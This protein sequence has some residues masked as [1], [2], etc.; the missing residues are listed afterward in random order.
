M[1]AMSRSRDIAKNSS[2]TQNYVRL[3]D[4]LS[5]TECG[6]AVVCGIIDLEMNE[7]ML[8]IP[9]TD[10]LNRKQFCAASAIYSCKKSKSRKIPIRIINPMVAVNTL[11]KGTILGKIVSYKCYI[12]DYNNSQCFVLENDDRISVTN[13][14]EDIMGSHKSLSGNE[15]KE[16]K[17]VVSDYKD[18]FSLSS[19]DVGHIKDYEHKILTRENPPIASKPRRIPMHLED[20]VEKLVNELKEKNIVTEAS[21]P[22]NSPVVIVP[23]KNGDIRLCIDYRRLN[24]IT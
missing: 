18:I 3:Q 21:S 13:M 16:L 22:W 6:E 12:E 1:S 19:T 11:Y 10:K 9:N 24:S 15:Y 17:K 8:F 2:E 20:K 4:N 23:K 7:D 14:V 5:L